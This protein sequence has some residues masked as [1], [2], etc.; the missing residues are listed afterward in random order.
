MLGFWGQAFGNYGKS[1]LARWCHQNGP[2][3][4]AS[5]ST[6]LPPDQMLHTLPFRGSLTRTS[7]DFQISQG[8]QEKG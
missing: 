7:A 2:A 6:K 4:L 5:R 1:I 3:H 8:I